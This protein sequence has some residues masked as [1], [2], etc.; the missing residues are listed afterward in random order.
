MDRRDVVVI[1]SGIGG[2]TAAALLAKAGL[3]TLL[4]EKNPRIG[5]SCSWYDKRGFRVDYGTHMFTRGHKGPLGDALRRVGAGREVRFVQVDDLAEVRGGGL[6]LVVP[7][8]PW[9]MPA[10]CIE[11]VRQLK[12]P[13]SELPRVTRL[14]YEILTM[15]RHEIEEWDGR[16]IEEF[17]HRYTQNPQVFGLLGFLLGLYFILPPWQ[18]SAGE[19]IL[20]FQAMV[21]DHMLSYPI[22]GSGAIPRALVSAF[23][24]YG[25]ETVTRAGCVSLEPH[26]EG[27]RVGLKN[28]QQVIARAVISTTTLPDLLRIAGE[29]R[30]PS[31]FVERTR[32]IRKSYVAVQAKVA[33]KRK[34][35]RSGCIVGGWARDSR[36]DPM[37]VTREDYRAQFAALD[38]GE[39]PIV[40][41]VYCPIPTNFDP[42][43]APAGGQLLTACAVAPTTDIKRPEDTREH[44]RNDSAFI[45][46]LLKAMNDLMPGCLDDAEF[47]DTMGVEALA[48]WIGKSGGPAVST[49]QTPEQSGRRRPPVRTPLPGLYVAG[50]AAGG[51]GI[52]T[53]LAAASAM[54]CVDALLADH[55]G[56]RVTDRAMFAEA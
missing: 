27:W 37:H 50:D 32:A 18:V 12:I 45:D 8:Q 35:E 30:F 21:K 15:P 19:S 42:A 40:V 9:R 31:Q 7:A 16:T 34:R 54:E 39:V 25:G 28:G 55:V 38:R 24:R 33:L 13:L 43:L 3:R 29:Q 56:R 47:V 17:I 14:F 23:E 41:P 20:C 53:E 5:G 52:G 48:S 4:A 10:F 2:C 36:F 26:A 51:R 11:A 6:H 44:A 1:G 46:G 49:G 22:G